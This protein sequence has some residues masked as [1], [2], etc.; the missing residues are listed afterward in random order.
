MIVL[1]W[2]C[3]GLGQPATILFLCELVRVYRPDI[4]FLFEKLSFGVRLESLR[5]KFKFNCC[6]TMDCVDRSGRL[7][8]FWNNN[9]NISV[10]S[11]SMNHVDLFILED[12]R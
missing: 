7:T 1:S 8:I 3:R 12:V 5:V 10:L 2:N 6:F 9:N 4:I 11:Y